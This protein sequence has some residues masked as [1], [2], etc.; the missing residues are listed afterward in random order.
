MVSY[1][2]SVSGSKGN[3]KAEL[4]RNIKNILETRAGSQPADRDFGISWK[5]LDEIPDVAESFF[6]LE[7][8]EKIERYEPR[9]EVDEVEFYHGAS[10][11]MIP[12]I[13]FVRRGNDE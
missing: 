1:S 4:E 11:Q 3:E 13:K 8:H 10:G 7:L 9:V 5:C 6:V 2:F 12:R